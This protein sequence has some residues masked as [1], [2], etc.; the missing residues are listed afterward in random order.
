MRKPLIY[1]CLFLALP[2][3]AHAN[4]VMKIVGFVSAFHAENG[5]FCTQGTHE[6][7]REKVNTLKMYEDIGNVW[8]NN[9][10]LDSYTRSA[11]AFVAQFAKRRAEAVRNSRA[12]K[13]PGAP[14]G[15]IKS[16]G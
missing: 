5:Q 3:Q 7:E 11:G 16:N 12:Y 4:P 2:A 14:G 6:R 9:A 15:C 10:E 13:G 8:A 1:A